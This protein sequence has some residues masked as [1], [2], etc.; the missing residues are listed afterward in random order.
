M[1]EMNNDEYKL[2]VQNYDRYHK[3]DQCLIEKYN[4]VAGERLI[5]A[6]GSPFEAS[7]ARSIVTKTTPTPLI[8]IVCFYVYRTL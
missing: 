5:P 3:L 8:I 4:V 6:G 2:V 7:M 1:Y